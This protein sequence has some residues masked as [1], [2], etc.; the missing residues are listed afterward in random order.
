MI[1]RTKREYDQSY[2]LISSAFSWHLSLKHLFNTALSL[3]RS[4]D[5]QSA[6]GA[7]LI[8]VSER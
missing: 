4:A 7:R 1:V 5:L 6:L 2:Q 8:S 3:S